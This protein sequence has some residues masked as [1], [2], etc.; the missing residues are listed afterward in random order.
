MSGMVRD[1]YYESDNKNIVARPL[2]GVFWV[3]GGGGGGGGG[4]GER[5]GSWGLRMSKNVRFQTSDSRLLSKVQG[6]TPREA[7]NN[8]RCTLNPQTPKPEPPT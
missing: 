1:D 2:G 6:L 3:E 7:P 5:S 8:M 4:V